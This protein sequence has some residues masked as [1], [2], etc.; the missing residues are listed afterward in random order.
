MAF[1]RFVIVR[2]RA[3]KRI[4]PGREIHRDVIM[5]PR[6]PRIVVAAVVFRPGGVPA[7]GMVRHGI[8]RG[9]IFANPEHCGDDFRFPWETFAALHWIAEVTRRRVTDRIDLEQHVL[10]KTVLFL[11]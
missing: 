3:V 5:A 6:R 7:A 2:Q 4:L 1:A 10:A 8:I 11:V 9:R